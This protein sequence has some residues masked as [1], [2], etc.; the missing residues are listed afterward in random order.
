V[1]RLLPD[2]GPTDVATELE[3]FQ[4]RAAAGAERPWVYT[5]FAVTLD[6][7]ATIGGR[8]GSIGSDTDTAMLMELRASADAV[9]IGAG[10]MRSER[11]GRLLPSAERRER[12]RQAGLAEDPLAVLVSG[13]LDLPWEAGLFSEG[14]GRV[15]IFTASETEPPPTATAVQLER[16]PGGIDLARALAQLRTDYGVAALLCEGGPLLHGE[17]LEQGLVDELFVTL[18]PKL[19][20]GEGPRLAE[21]LPAGERRLELRWLLREGAGELFARYAVAR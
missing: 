16:H 5:N 20:G 10:T 1:E 14:A 4:P 2:P 19:A 8:S 6:G 3:R 7:Q 13:G 21:G 9:L 17:L 15:V 12:R 11:Y 18:A